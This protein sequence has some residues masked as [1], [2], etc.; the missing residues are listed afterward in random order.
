MNKIVFFMMCI[1]L[2]SACERREVKKTPEMELQ[3]REAIQAYLSMSE[4]PL[5]E[6]KPIKSS[7][8][9]SPDF[10]YIYI[11]GNRCIEF[12]VNCHG[13]NCSELQKYPYHEHGEECP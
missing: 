6:L 9:P 5:T 1:S 3:A 8:Q 4:L 7:A 2:L 13:E 11:N 10:S 12:I